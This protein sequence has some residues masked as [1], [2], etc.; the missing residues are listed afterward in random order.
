MAASACLRGRPGRGAGP[1]P[2]IDA[3][4]P[5]RARSRCGRAPHPTRSHRTGRRAGIGSL[6]TT[7]TPIAP[8]A[9]RY[10]HRRRRANRADRRRHA[11]LRGNAEYTHRWRRRGP[12]RRWPP[13]TASRTCRRRPGRRRSRPATRRRDQ[14]HLR[15]ASGSAPQRT[16]P[17]HPGHE[18]TAGQADRLEGG[19]AEVLGEPGRVTDEQIQPR[20]RSA[21]PTPQPSATTARARSTMPRCA[22]PGSRRRSRRRRSAPTR[23]SGPMRTTDTPTTVAPTARMGRD[24][25]RRTSCRHHVSAGPAAGPDVDPIADRHAH[26]DEVLGRV[27]AHAATS[28]PCVPR[29]ARF[30]PRLTANP[31]M[32]SPVTHQIRSRARIFMPSSGLMNSE[33]GRGRRCA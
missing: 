15:S 30:R 28:M 9:N 19:E 24:A 20:R 29:N 13:S 12:P 14:P 33:G 17:Q 10:R 32:V 1:V 22:T 4:A 2:P 31:A 8:N 26:E 23:K 25:R 5:G 6:N 18:R 7:T 11:D 21:G 27:E 3:L 16:R